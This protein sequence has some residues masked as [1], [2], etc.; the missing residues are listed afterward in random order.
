MSEIIIPEKGNLHKVIEFVERMSDKIDTME[1]DAT[2]KVA[3]KS[4][5]LE[6]RQREL[7]ETNE[8]LALE[9]E[10]LK[11]Q[12]NDD[13]L[14][15]WPAFNRFLVREKSLPKSRLSGEGTN[16]FLIIDEYGLDDASFD[17][18]EPLFDEYELALHNSLVNRDRFLETSAPK[19][20]KALQ[21]GDKD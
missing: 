5:E 21:G 9:V 10:G 4:A 14:A 2:S 17:R 12:L 3:E 15:A 18:L 13:Q 1:A 20:Y 16:L 19:L 11:S 7:G 6:T 8:A